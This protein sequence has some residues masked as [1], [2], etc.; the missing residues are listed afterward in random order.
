VT[1]AVLRD[2]YGILMDQARSS[3]WI[4][5]NGRWITGAHG[6]RTSGPTTMAMLAIRAEIDRLT[7]RSPNAPST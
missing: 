2:I 4:S 7:R 6:S 1:T 5:S 3:Q